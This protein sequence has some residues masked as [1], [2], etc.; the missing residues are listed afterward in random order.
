[1]QYWITQ[2]WPLTPDKV[3][4]AMA[5]IGWEMGD[6]GLWQAS[7]VPLFRQSL[8]AVGGYYEEH[9]L[10]GVLWNLTDVVR[11]LFGR[12]RLNGKRL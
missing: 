11:M 9:G 12:T 8:F 10:D 2:D 1:M 7:T 6:D 4:A 5:G 3:P